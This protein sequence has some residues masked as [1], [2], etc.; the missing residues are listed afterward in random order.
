MASPFSRSLV[1]VCALRV[2]VC[3]LTSPFAKKNPWLLHPP[4]FL[5][6]LTATL[7]PLRPVGPDGLP[8]MIGA[9]ARQEPGIRG[10]PP[11]S[12]RKPPEFL[13][14]VTTTR[15][16]FER[17]FSPVRRPSGCGSS[18]VSSSRGAKLSPAPVLRV[19]CRCGL[20]HTGVCVCV[21]GLRIKPT[22]H[23]SGASP[24]RVR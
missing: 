20:T 7:L 14:T 12:W 17:Q 9:S 21:C 16:N 3:A 24:V 2:G 6:A 15:R 5:V 4:F 18:S 13:H 22:K 10:H 23:F 11:G 19:W 1:Q 8:I